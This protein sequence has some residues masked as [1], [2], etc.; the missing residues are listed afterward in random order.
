MLFYYV[1]LMSLMSLMSA[2]LLNAIKIKMKLIRLYV[3]MKNI[4][5]MSVV[6]LNVVAPKFFNQSIL[7][8]CINRKEKIGGGRTDL[9]KHFL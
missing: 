6:L 5:L 7:G 8:N 2:V 4:I 1:C 9:I 3:I